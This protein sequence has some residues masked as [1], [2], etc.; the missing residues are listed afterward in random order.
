MVK[1]KAPTELTDKLMSMY[2]NDELVRLG[3]NE[4]YR[5]SP[6]K[7]WF[8][9]MEICQFL[10]TLKFNNNWDKEDL[11]SLAYFLVP[12]MTNMS[13]RGDMVRCV[14]K[15]AHQL[16]PKDKGL[17]N[18]YTSGR[19]KACGFCTPI[20]ATTREKKTS[21]NSLTASRDMSR[22]STKAKRAAAKRVQANQNR[23]RDA[24]K[25]VTDVRQEPTTD[26]PQIETETMKN[27][28]E[29]IAAFNETDF[30]QQLESLNIASLLAIS[31]TINN[32]ILQKTHNI[33]Q[34]VKQAFVE[35]LANL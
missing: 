28:A 20:H 3:E 13:L 5:R 2:S 24:D 27:N 21:L 9:G 31:T 19:G 33:E 6:K 7:H 17:A 29:T 4:A 30:A 35:K 26:Q 15:V 10:L 25:K 14:H 8:T 32:L 34:E 11:A 16:L 22:K 18:L 12:H 23:T 1:I